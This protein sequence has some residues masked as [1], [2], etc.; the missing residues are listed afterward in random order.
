MILYDFDAAPNAR[1]VR[2]FMAEKGV[3]C[4]RRQID[5]VK[6]EN[7]SDSYRRINPA[8]L[9]PALETDE[10]EVICESVAICRYL[11]ALRPQPNLMGQDP[12]E[13]A[14][15]ELWERRME[16]EGILAISYAFRETT[17][18][19]RDRAAAGSSQAFPQIP[20]LAERGMVLA[21]DFLAMLE[22]RLGQ[23]AFVGGERFTI[24]DVT[25]FASCGFAKWVGLDPA[26]SGANL[27]RWYGEMRQR[28]SANA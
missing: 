11:E 6:G 10:G 3:T 18:T 17:P 2:M 16:R 13:T 23:S 15:I 28:P 22:S 19:F 5:I 7:L 25:A 12:L 24:A 9:I 1:R 20:A 4:E 26:S 21:L 8:G 27:A 14:R